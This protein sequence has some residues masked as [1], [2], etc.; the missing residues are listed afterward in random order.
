[1]EIVPGESG[2]LDTC[3]IYYTIKNNSE[4]GKTVG[5]RF[6][7][8][9]YIGAND[10]V[11]FTIPGEK[12]FLDTMR[13]FPQKQIPDYIE[14]IEKPD[15]PNDPGTVARMGL[16]NIKLPGVELEDIEL[17]RICRWPGTRNTRW[18]VPARPMNEP[19]DNKDS[20]VVLYWPY[21][22]I[23]AGEDRRMAFTYGLG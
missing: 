4:V 22:K 15:D 10:G 8:D 16:K 23:N 1:V 18:D 6:L 2:V 12:G 7:M 21:Q 5:L 14:A 9:T 13:D 19:A 17:L 20:C 3:L 11:P